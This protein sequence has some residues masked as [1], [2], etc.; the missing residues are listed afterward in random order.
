MMII[1]L[2][3]FGQLLVLSLSHCRVP[4]RRALP[5]KIAAELSRSTTGR[6]RAA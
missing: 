5:K 6:S 4:S 1:C 2:V 3:K